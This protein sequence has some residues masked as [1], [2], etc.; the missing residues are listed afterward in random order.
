MCLDVKDGQVVKGVGFKNLRAVG[1]PVEM[2]QRYETEGADEIVFLDVSATTE[3][4]RT[5]LDVAERTSRRLFIPLTIGGGMRSVAD[6]GRALRAGADKVGVNSAA[7]DRPELLTDLAREFGSQCIV[8]S[9]DA[10]AND[11]GW[12]VIVRSG[13]TPT[14]RD[15]IAW[16]RECAERGAGE[17]LITSVDRD[18]TRDGYDLELLKAIRGVA[19]VPI[20]ASGGA[21]CPKD[22][23][24]VLRITD[25]DAAL[26]AGILHDGD[27]TVMAIKDAMREANIPVRQL[28]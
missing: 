8:S 21:G 13:T 17:L 10:S 5:I 3:D 2:A 23:V 4:R 22:V 1:D 27:T 6:V 14:Q 25:I 28:T 16:A 11:Q 12:E 9:I 24:D 19:A 15:A 26:V 7:V 18:G 20:I